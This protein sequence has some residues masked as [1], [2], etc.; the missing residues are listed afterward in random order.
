MMSANAQQRLP[1]CG[2]GARARRLVSMDFPT[3][4]ERDL[5]QG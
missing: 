1:M 5:G 4:R 3:V 2:A